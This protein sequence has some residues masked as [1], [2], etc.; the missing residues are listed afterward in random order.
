[1][2]YY[3]SVIQTLV[4]RETVVVGD[5]RRAPDVRRAVARGRE[6]QVLRWVEADG[7]DGAAVS[8]V[9]KEALVVGQIFLFKKSRV[10][11]FQGLKINSKHGF[12]SSKQLT[13][14]QITL[15]W[16]TGSPGPAANRWETNERTSVLGVLLLF[17]W[18]CSIDRMFN[19]T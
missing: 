11:A 5:D 1:M 16:R 6:R 19:S 13:L 17:D 10:P 9:G 15:V 2:T 18:N 7:V 3:T 14:S 8:S 12:S 4:T